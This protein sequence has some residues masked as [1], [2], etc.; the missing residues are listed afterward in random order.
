MSNNNFYGTEEISSLSYME[1]GAIDLS[2][3]K[4][5][6]WD[7]KLHQKAYDWYMH[8]RYSN[9]ILCYKTMIE[10]RDQM[11]I[12]DML[13]LYLDEIHHKDDFSVNIG[14]LCALAVAHK[15]VPSAGDLSF[16][17]LGQTLF[18]CIETMELCQKLITKLKADFNQINLLD[19]QWFGVDISDFFNRLSVIMHSQYNLHTYNDV[20]YLDGM[21]D[22]FFAKGVTMLYAIRSVEQLIYFLNSA[23]IC[24]FD[25]SFAVK[26]EHDLII[27]S[28][29]LVKYL[30]LNDFVIELQRLPGK[31]YVKKGNSFYD[32]QNDRVVLD[33]LYANDQ[34]CQE[35]I[36][37]DSSVRNVLGSYL[38]EQKGADIFLDSANAKNS[39]WTTLGEFIDSCVR[40]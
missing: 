32:Q 13:K 30:K 34:T 31:L 40:K 28:G 26:E 1:F 15:T 38:A 21:K 6:V 4:K 2:S 10:Q 35:F 7:L 36:A 33:C 18:G 16:F 23:K 14:K 9:D 25:Y 5:L 3:S 12:E 22:V 37:L 17:E 29:K 8:A 19:V 11:S 20:K 27:G 39:G 24:V